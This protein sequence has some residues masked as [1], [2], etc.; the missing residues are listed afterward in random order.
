MDFAFF[1]SPTV[2]VV[3][4]VCAIV[5]VLGIAGSMLR[6]LAARDEAERQAAEARRNANNCA[7]AQAPVDLTAEPQPRKHAP[8]L[9][10]AAQIAKSAADADTRNAEPALETIGQTQPWSAPASATLTSSPGTEQSPI[11][12]DPELVVPHA[13]VT[14]LAP[15]FTSQASQQNTAPNVKPQ[16]TAAPGSIVAAELAA[17]QQNLRGSA[18]RPTSLDDELPDPTPHPTSSTPVVQASADDAPTRVLHLGSNQPANQ[19]FAVADNH[20]DNAPHGRIESDQVSL[21]DREQPDDTPTVVLAATTKKRRVAGLVSQDNSGDHD[22]TAAGEACVAD[23]SGDDITIGSVTTT[24]G[25]IPVST[26]TKTTEHGTPAA[27]PTGLSSIP[28]PQ[29]LASRKTL[30]LQ[31]GELDTSDADGAASAN[32]G[33]NADGANYSGTEDIGLIPVQ[34]EDTPHESAEP[35]VRLKTEMFLTERLE[36]TEPDMADE[37]HQNGAFESWRTPAEPLEF[38]PDCPLTMVLPERQDRDPVMSPAPVASPR[39]AT[40]PAPYVPETRSSEPQEAEVLTPAIGGVE[41]C[42]APE[43]DPDSRAALRRKRI[44]DL[45]AGVPDDAAWSRAPLQR[46]FEF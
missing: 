33:G 38:R 14:E 25:S 24:T 29:F 40:S 43:V 37:H 26:S 7:T 5:A 17:S 8:R 19:T 13:S 32:T 11:W 28:Q 18:A 20:D 2:V 15:I 12:H 1:S 30:P 36:T 21:A 23:G 39:Q 22:Q 3:F 45:D 31:P 16:V 4:V 10:L 6:T 34:A 27:I 44:A 9:A 41:P 35:Q 42:N 46:D